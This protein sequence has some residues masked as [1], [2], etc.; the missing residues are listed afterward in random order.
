VQWLQVSQQNQAAQERA[1]QLDDELGEIDA[2]MEG[3][4]ERRAT[5]EARFE[6]LDQQLAQEQERHAELD[7]APMFQL[8]FYK[9][10]QLQDKKQKFLFQVELNSLREKQLLFQ[11]FLVLLQQVRQTKLL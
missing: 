8:A 7:E 3:L 1:V 10:L 2:Q 11:R 4:Q 6:E 9:M 5:G